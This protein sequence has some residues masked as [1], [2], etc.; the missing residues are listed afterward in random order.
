MFHKE[1]RRVGEFTIV[2]TCGHWF[3]TKGFPI[4]VGMMRKK[5]RD[6]V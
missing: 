6:G 1:A 4:H 2:C 5:A 3:S